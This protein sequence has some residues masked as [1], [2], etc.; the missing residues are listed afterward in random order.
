MFFLGTSGTVLAS[1]STGIST[2]IIHELFERPDGDQ[3]ARLLRL[4][5]NLDG[6]SITQ[7]V[8]MVV[9]NLVTDLLS[10]ISPRLTLRLVISFLCDLGS[11]KTHYSDWNPNCGDHGFHIDPRAAVILATGTNIILTCLTAGRIWYIRRDAALLLG[12][13]GVHKSYDTATATILETGMIYCLCMT[14]Q[15]IA[16]SLFIDT[17]SRYVSPPRC[18]QGS[19]NP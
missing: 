1:I 11:E 2:K 8:L 19:S 12:W 5:Q 14:I 6:L 13:K 18:K 7:G 16:D 17:L 3:F 9:N 4:Q 15:M 10:G